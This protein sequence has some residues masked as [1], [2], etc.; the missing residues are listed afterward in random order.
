MSG[1]NYVNTASTATTAAPI[2][3][4]DTT[5]TVASYTGYPSAP[6]WAELEKGT[7]SAEIVRVTNVAGSTLTI[8]RGQGGTSATSHGAGVTV[9]HIVPA[10]H[11]NEGEAHN[12]ATTAHGVTGV[13]VGTQGSQTIQDKTFR[14]A[15]RSDYTDAL[16]AGVTASFE[17]NAN[18]AAARDG[19]VHKNTAGDAARSGFLLQQSGTDRFKVR[20][21]G[22]VN[23]NPSASANPG[24]RNQ[25]TSQL[26]GNTTVGGTLAVTG[27]TTLSAGATVT[28]TVTATTVTATGTVN[29]LTASILGTVHAD[30]GLDTDGTLTVDGASTLTGA[31]TAGAGLTV[32]Q[33]V[34]SWGGVLVPSVASTASVTSPVSGMVVF[35]Q[36]SLSFKRRVGAAWV[37]VTPAVATG[38]D[39]TLLTTTSTAYTET[40]TGGSPLGFTFVAPPSGA[41]MV[42]NSALADNSTT[43][44][45]HQSWIIRNGAVVGSGTTFLDGDDRKSMAS[46]GGDDVIATRSAYVSGL[47]VGSTY[48]I[49]QQFRVSTASTGSF[50][51]RELT[52]V[53]V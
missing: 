52:V 49:R 32:A 29:G 51:F 46:V 44:R 53:P 18:S 11:F 7:G 20:N 8:T 28:G 2:G 15:H 33:N 31:V 48:N 22:T 25:S 1:E 5:V 43:G 12:A 45:S 16:P 47:T 13:V 30:G 23:I 4:A 37:A 14:G 17:S 3:P 19:F 6:Y 34:T 41:V 10:S 9:E 24:L 27:A 21:D 35:D 40:M 36:S 26:D 38:S 39:D 42:H 50:Q